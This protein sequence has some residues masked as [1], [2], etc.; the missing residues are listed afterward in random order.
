MCSGVV[1]VI[2]VIF[3]IF[4]CSVFTSAQSYTSI[5]S[6]HMFTCNS[7]FSLYATIDKKRPVHR[8]VFVT[9]SVTSPRV[10]TSF[11]KRKIRKII[12]RFVLIVSSNYISDKYFI[13][14]INIS[15]EQDNVVFKLQNWPIVEES[16]LY[17]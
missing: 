4:F 8:T 1:F 17:P 11:F 6:I 12:I 13:I 7:L 14:S 10:T 3:Y 16:A 5:L 2:V 15:F 9:S